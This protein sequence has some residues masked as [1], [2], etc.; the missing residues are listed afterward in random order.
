MSDMLVGLDKYVDWVLP[1]LQPHTQDIIKPWEVVSL[2][3]VFPHPLQKKLF[4]LILFE[5]MW[6]IDGS[7]TS[8]FMESKNLSP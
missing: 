3:K 7:R 6:A 8:G 2:I 4:H 1:A 5:E